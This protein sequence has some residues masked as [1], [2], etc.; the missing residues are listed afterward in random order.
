MPA[1][2][3]SPRRRR[4]GAC[5]A[6]FFWFAGLLVGAVLLL[7]VVV[8]RTPRLYDPEF[9]GRLDLLRQRL[10]ETPNRPLLFFV[11]SSRIGN[12]LHPEEMPEV[13]TAGGEPVLAFNFGHLAGGPIMSLIQVQRLLHEG[14]RPQW[15]VIEMAPLIMTGE[16]TG[17]LTTESGAGDLPTLF[18]YIDP[19]QVALVYLRSRLNP[20][21]KHRQTLLEMFA[22]AL[23]CPRD[24][25]DDMRLNAQGGDNFWISPRVLAPDEIRK[26]TNKAL[27]GVRD[28]LQDYHI[29]PDADRALRE[30]LALC[31]REG[32]AAMLVMTPEST[33]FRS[34]YS[35]AAH[36]R[37]AAY[38]ADIE[39]TCGVPVVDG[40]GWVPDECF[41]DG[42]HVMRS[43][44]LIFTYHLALWVLR[45][46]VLGHYHPQTTAVAAR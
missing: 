21:Y 15:L 16:S 5:R 19:G 10:A 14:I 34:V 44:G 20:W 25:Q 30:L 42:H 1:R 41:T 35:K 7:N 38:V 33:E 32:I 26:R 22:P 23:A 43:G 24:E 4:L 6:D 8:D 46:W 39:R 45:P 28:R 11:G 13:R 40:R 37:I 9:G 12:G 29:A 36:R 27:A 17:T 31:R 3:P 2:T 18:R